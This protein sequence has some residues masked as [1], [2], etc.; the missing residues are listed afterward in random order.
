MEPLKSPENGEI[1]LGKNIYC[2]SELTIRSSTSEACYIKLKNSNGYDVFAF[3]VRPG[4]T[5]TVSVPDGYYY[6]YFAYGNDWYGTE[7]IFGS[8]TTYAKDDKLL[9]F[10]NYTWSYTLYPSIG[11]N[12][13]ET[14]ISADEF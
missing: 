1:L 10:E 13:T 4:S 14:P 12:F 5:A 2:N 8:E 11:G 7:Y 6:V 3:F 9:D